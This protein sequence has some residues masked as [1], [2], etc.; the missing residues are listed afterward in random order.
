MRL[1][2]QLHLHTT[3]SKG[4]RIVVDSIINPKQ[5][6]DLAKRNGIDVIA[7]TDHDTTSAYPKI[8]KHAEESG[9]LLINGIEIKTLDGH[10]IGLDV[11]V[12]LEENLS[13]PITTLEA[14]D[15]IKDSGGEVYIPHLFDIRNAGIGT[16]IKEI[17]GIVEVFNPLDIFGFEDRYADLV[18]SRL[19]KPKAVGADA[20][21]PKMLNLCLTVVDS[22][23]DT[24]SILNAIKKGKTEFKNCR[25]LTLREMKELSLERV[26]NSYDYIKNKIRNGWE[27][28]R[29]YM[30]LANNPL[31]KILEDFTLELGMRTKKSKIW[32][33]VVCISHI[34]AIL[35]AK[36]TKREF[37]A[38][39]SNL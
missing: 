1:T 15:L 33:F 6:V 27:V 9:I 13:R 38:F 23:P 30:I 32:D 18:A 14:R 12:G 3:E 24:H 5:A 25:H 16:K 8:K 35:Y 36:K 7:V 2:A 34:L 22:E 28:D 19:G 26:S 29:G 10:L 11:D 39:I 20:H 21:L 37:D 31:M 4:T 17:D